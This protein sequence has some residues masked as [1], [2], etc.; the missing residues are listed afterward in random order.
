MTGCSEVSPGCTNCYAKVIAERYRGT[1]AYPQGFDVTLRPHKLRDPIKWREPARV[2]VNSMSDLFHREIPDDYLVKIWAT[3]LEADRHAYLILTK[4]AH[5]MAHKI[6][7][8][9]LEVADHIWLGISAEN[10]DMADSRV[11]ALLSIGSNVPWV[12][13]EPLLAPID[14]RPYLSQD[15]I[16]WI[17]VG[18][19]SGTQRRHMEYD[20]A[21]AIRDHCADAGVAMFFKQG[22]HVRAGRDNV[23]DGRN[24]E[25]YPSFAKVPDVVRDEP[26]FIEHQGVLV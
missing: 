8:L 14:F 21:R 22:N 15:G 25:E 1:A 5:R 10:Q 7:E 18:G 26:E 23:L 2:F 17:V 9:G 24:H 6:K 3:M 13:A 12:S 4:R 19:E 20:W 11:P 16:K